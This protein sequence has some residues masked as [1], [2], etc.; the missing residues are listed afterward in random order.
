MKKQVRIWE[1]LKRDFPDIETIADKTEIW[2]HPSGKTE[3][4][5]IIHIWSKRVHTV[6]EYKKAKKILLNVLI[7]S[8][9]W[10]KSIT[11]VGNV[12]FNTEKDGIHYSIIVQI[13]SPAVRNKV[14]KCNIVAN[15]QKYTGTSWVCAR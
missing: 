4:T 2:I 5:R 12:S 8:N 11:S 13:H 10:E 9:R 15:E 7:R 3:D 6:D 1:S 14:F